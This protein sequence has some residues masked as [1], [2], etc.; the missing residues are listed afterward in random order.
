MTRWTLLLL[1]LVVGAVGCG[2]RSEPAPVEKRPEPTARGAEEEVQATRQILKALS[3]F[4]DRYAADHEGA[5]PGAVDDLLGA[6]PDGTPYVGAV[7]VDAWGRS[8]RF[9]PKEDGSFEVRSAG[10]D[11]AMDTADDVV[12]GT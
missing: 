5:L 8:I 7:P 6:D 11:G 9:T 2:D 4:V 12:V 10:A 3:N 1:L